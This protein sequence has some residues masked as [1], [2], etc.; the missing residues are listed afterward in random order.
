VR[1]VCRNGGGDG[2][3]YHPARTPQRGASGNRGSRDIE[4]NRVA[5]LAW[6]SA[7]GTIPA[8]PGRGRLRAAQTRAIAVQSSR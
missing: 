7:V 5:R 1:Q 2:V 6:S 4:P 8:V 3:R